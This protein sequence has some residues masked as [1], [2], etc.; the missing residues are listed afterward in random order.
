MKSS[1]LVSA[2]LGVSLV[3]NALLAW[4]LFSAPVSPPPIVPPPVSS[5]VAAPLP[6]RPAGSDPHLV[7][8]DRLLSLGLSDTEVRAALRA[9]IAAPRLARQRQL[10]SL[11]TPLPWWQGFV[12]GYRFTPEQEAELRG[13]RLAERTELT[14]LFGRTGAL[15]P[16]DVEPYLFLPPDRAASLAALERDY[17]ELHAQLAEASP[18]D[19]GASDARR[20]ELDREHD[21]D[22]AALLS[23]EE[24]TALDLHSSPTARALASRMAYFEGTEAEFR[25]VYDLQKAFDEKFPATAVTVVL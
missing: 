17:R 9:A 3:A 14:R 2:L 18:T 12:V 15:N 16:A 4:L 11:T 5:A 19:P 24:R 13:L 23:R 22:L 1:S 25:A 21:R 8:R 10:R 7:L 6:T 20:R